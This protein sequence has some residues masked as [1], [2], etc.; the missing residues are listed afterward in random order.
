MS[1]P[2][3]KLPKK[4]KAGEPFEI[5]TL[6]P[7]K[8][9]SGQRKNK[10]T[11]ELIPRNIINRFVC[12]LDGEEVYAVTLHSAVSA[13]PYIAFWLVVDAP[14]TLEFVWIDDDEKEISSEKSFEL[15]AG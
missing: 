15:V 8:M 4:I 13:N 10:D 12:R 5:K 14:G 6:I 9:E 7:H 11:G 1:R 2:R 3:I